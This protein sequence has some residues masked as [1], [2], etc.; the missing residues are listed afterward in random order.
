MSIDKFSTREQVMDFLEG[1]TQERKEELDK[2]QTKKGLIKSYLLETVPGYSKEPQ[3]EKIFSQ[4][5][6][7]LE[8]IDDTL[9]KVWDPEQEAWYQTEKTNIKIEGKFLTLQG[10]PVVMKFSK[11]LSDKVFTQWITSTFK[12]KRNK[13]RL[14]GHPIFLGSK[15]VHVYGADRHL[16][17]PIYLEIT[18]K[19][20]IAILP[21][22][23]CGNTIHRLVTNIQRYIDSEIDVSIGNLS[24]K[25]MI[26]KA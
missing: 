9:Y 10:A 16:W 8:H 12:R 19:H 5:G 18:N 15:K 21:K 13:F 25:E 2:K 26:K 20:L 7:K 4:L 11:V 24:Y 14:W 3:T 6:I 17:Q 23:T 1:Y 22:G